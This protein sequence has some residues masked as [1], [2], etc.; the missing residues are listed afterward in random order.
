M[1]EFI[2]SL[3]NNKETAVKIITTFFILILNPGSR[4]FAKKVIRKVAILGAKSD[5]RINQVSR[6][7]SYFI[8]G[9]CLIILAIIWGVDPQ[10]VVV[11]FSSLFTIIG[12]AMFAQWS[13]LSNITAG[14][15]IY[16]SMP[17][18]V[19]DEI[20]IYD[21]EMP[22]LGTIENIMTFTLHIRTPE[23]DLVVLSN[24]VFLQK[25][26]FIR[27]SNHSSNEPEEN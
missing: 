7:V 10:S 14:I 21:K 3:L 20:E 9:S 27:R 5:F 12:V 24:I 15:I 8:N 2:H 16:F 11:V 19:G 22:V 25:M 18:R 13:I 17:F 6:L 23:G 1:F 4:Y 26:L